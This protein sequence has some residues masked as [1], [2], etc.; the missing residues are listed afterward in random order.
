M[1][2]FSTIEERAA[3]R[4]GG[5]KA[6][7]ALLEKPSSRDKV[8]D[9]PDDRFL[10]AMTRCIFQAG[11]NWALIDKKWPA[12]EAAFEGFDVG[13]WSLMSDDD[14]DRLLKTP[15][16][17]ANAAKL[18]SVGE[19]ARFI[20][21]LRAEAGGAGAYFAQ[22]GLDRQMALQTELK[23]RGARLGGRTG[24]IFLRRMGVDSIIFSEAVVGA[25]IRAKVVDKSPSSKA[26][27]QKVQDALNAWHAQTGRGATQIS[28]ILGY[29]VD[30]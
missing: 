21:E 6:L 24:Q 22:F 26:D 1:V 5:K 9:T 30:V 15:G 12:F 3:A 29:S 8:A 17:V 13:R 14:L 7:E 4:K 19:N 27:L 18:R 11:F 10:S 20:L 28:Q 23:K 25:L 16:L 2:G